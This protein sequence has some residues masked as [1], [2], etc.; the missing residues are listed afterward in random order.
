MMRFILFVYFDLYTSHYQFTLI[1]QLQVLT[2]IFHQRRRISA[3]L[4]KITSNQQNANYFSAAFVFCL[5]HYKMKVFA[6]L[7]QCLSA[8]LLIGLSLWPVTMSPNHSR[9][10]HLESVHSL[11]VLL[12]AQKTFK[13]FKG[14]QKKAVNKRIKLSHRTTLGTITF[15]YFFHTRQKRNTVSALV[16]IRAQLPRM[17]L[18][19]H[20]HA[21]LLCLF[22]NVSLTSSFYSTH[23]L[24]CTKAFA[25]SKNSVGIF[26]FPFT[27]TGGRFGQ[28]RLVG[29]TSELFICTT[30]NQAI[31]ATLPDTE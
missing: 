21:S 27:Q 16:D 6:S 31:I 12:F 7:D 26:Q 28:R 20:N 8:L 18:L 2:I 19:A 17:S 22:I 25:L 9:Q 5:L 30:S 15:A 1:S 14:Q 4:S 29:K 3:V 11:A 10:L 23:L 13:S 24:L